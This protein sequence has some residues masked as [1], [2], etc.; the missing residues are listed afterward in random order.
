MK[1]FYDNLDPQKK[2]FFNKLGSVNE[3]SIESFTPFMEKEYAVMNNEGNSKYHMHFRVPI[4]IQNYD[5]NTKKSI[6]SKLE[7]YVESA[8]GLSGNLKD[9]QNIGEVESCRY[10]FN[11]DEGDKINFNLVSDRDIKLGNMADYF[12]QILDRSCETF[13]YPF[14]YMRKN[15]PYIDH[16][17]FWPEFGL[18]LVEN[19]EILTLK[20][21]KDKNEVVESLKDV[22]VGEIMKTINKLEE[23]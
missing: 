7:D 13:N 5:N 12:G 23:L 6:Q 8:L 22:S 4:I 10:G 21:E 1:E 16:E 18:T 19:N 20:G 2:K 14:I 17:C 9:L 15:R 3:G 11:P